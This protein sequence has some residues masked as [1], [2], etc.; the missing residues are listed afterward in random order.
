MLAGQTAD[1]AIAH[2]T[3]PDRLA[4]D[5]TVTLVDPF[6][7]IR[8]VAVHCLPQ[9]IKT[10]QP[11]P[12]Q[13]LE[14]SEKIELR[15]EN[16]KA[17]GTW[18]VPKAAGKPAVVS[19]QPVL[20][21]TE[22]KPFYLPTTHYRFAPLPAS[23]GRPPLPF[24]RPVAGGNRKVHPGG[25]TA[26]GDKLLTGGIVALAERG[27]GL[28]FGVVQ[29]GET[30]MEFTYFAIVRFPATTFRRT[31]F[32]TRQKT[33]GEQTRAAYGAYLDDESLTVEHA[34]AADKIPLENE[35]LTILEEQFDPAD[36]RVFLVDFRGAE[37]TVVQ[38]KFDLPAALDRVPL[39][40]EHILNL[41]D[42]TLAEL[43]KAHKQV[44]TFVEGKK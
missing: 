36:G 37:P 7:K 40:D 16:R 12:Q 39:D 23:P 14:Q 1:V 35:E 10:P 27:Q 5:V 15:I 11:A 6:H 34:F 20:I 29:T 44:Q 43:V 18:V 13:P 31:T 22:G 3:E 28:G 4:V 42:K 9:E 25:A 41:A 33:T 2:R 17:F 8:S 38:H 21:D 19:L 32:T 26:L 30:T 24:P